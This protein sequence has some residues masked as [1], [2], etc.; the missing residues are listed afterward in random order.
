MM[1][2]PGPRIIVAGRHMVAVQTSTCRTALNA[3]RMVELPLL[4]RGTD[5]FWQLRPPWLFVRNPMA[6]EQKS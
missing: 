5:P 3:L 6:C 1:M 2:N 4:G